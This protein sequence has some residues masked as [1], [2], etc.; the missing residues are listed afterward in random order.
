MGIT[1]R[2]VRQIDKTEIEL[3]PYKLRKVQL[4]TEKKVRYLGSRRP[5]RVVPLT[6]TYRL[7]RS[8]WSRTRENWAAAEWNQV[9][10]SEESRFSLSSDDN[11]VRVWSPRD[12]RLN[13]AFPLQRHT[14][15]TA[16]V[17]V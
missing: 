2:S 3:K 7:L 9:I 6:P 17:M 8:D 15:P 16:G 10:L 5:L 11:R 4:L 1:V 13:F 12:K 14:T